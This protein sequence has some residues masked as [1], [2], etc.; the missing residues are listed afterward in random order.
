MQ[1]LNIGSAFNRI[2]DL[3]DTVSGLTKWTIEQ[4]NEFGNDVVGCDDLVILGSS[5]AE[6]LEG[7]KIVGLILDEETCPA[8]GVYE[9]AIR[10]RGSF[11]GRGLDR[12]SSHGFRRGR[13]C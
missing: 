2:N 12:D 7:L 4:G 3:K 6:L 9:E 8:G 11:P 13:E 10:H 1:N 5:E